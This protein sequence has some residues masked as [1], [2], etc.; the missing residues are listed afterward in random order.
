M[1]S[2]A[3]NPDFIPNAGL[4]RWSCEWRSAKAFQE[5]EAE[6]FSRLLAIPTTALGNWE[7]Q[8]IGCSAVFICG[9]PDAFRDG[10]T[11]ILISNYE[12]FAF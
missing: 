5:L 4:T 8:M 1:R 6:S 2:I 12:V 9:I 11:T 10:P 3:I 7:V